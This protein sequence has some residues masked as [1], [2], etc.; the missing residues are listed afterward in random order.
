MLCVKSYPADVVTEER[1]GSVALD[2]HTKAVG[3]KQRFEDIG[4]FELFCLISATALLDNQGV[5]RASRPSI[6]DK[7]MQDH[8]KI[9]AE[10][11]AE[12]CAVVLVEAE[13][14]ESMGE[15]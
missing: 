12:D 15:E 4:H 8:Q 10:R 14:W 5:A 2:Y 3:E 6:L 1:R 13:R 11:L 7:M 9:I